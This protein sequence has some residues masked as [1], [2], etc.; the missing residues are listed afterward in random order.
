MLNLNLAVM[1][2]ITIFLIMING[3]KKNTYTK[4][5]RGMQ[6]AFLFGGRGGGK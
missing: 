4:A 3:K 2:I 6:Y 1:Y 5:T